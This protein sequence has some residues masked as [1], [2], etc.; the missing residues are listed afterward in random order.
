MASS[1]STISRS[2]APLLLV[3]LAACE[4][5]DGE[6]RK[7]DTEEQGAVRNVTLP[8][9]PP[10]L[11][12][13]TLSGSIPTFIPA[14]PDS[15]QQL[16][17]DS[18]PAAARP[19]FDSFSWQSFIALNWPAADGERGVPQAPGDSTVFL[20]A[21]NGTPVVWG[22]YKESYELY[23]Q[24]D[25]RPSPWASWDNPVDVCGGGK[26]GQKVFQRVSKGTSVLDQVDEAFSYPLV[27]QNLQYSRY[28]VRY[29]QAYYDTVRGPDSDPTRWMYL[30]KNLV[31]AMPFQMPATDSGGAV[32]ALMIKA[33]WRPMA[34]NDDRSRFYVID[35]QVLESD[36]SCSTVSMGLVGLHIAQKLSGFPQWI[37]STFEHVG[38]VPGPGSQPPYSYNNGLDTP[39]TQGGWANRPDTVGVVPDSLRARAQVVRLNPIPTTPQG[40]STR[41]VNAIYQ[42]Y[43][44]G[45]VWANYE[46][47]VTQ[48][49][50]NP[51]TFRYME[52]G[53]VYPK[54]SGTAFPVNG[55]VNT[56][57][58]TFFQSPSDAAGAGGNSCMSCHYRADYTDY[59][60][61][62]KRRAH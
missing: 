22:T 30:A 44:S 35:A 28:E 51:S 21:A 7:Q 23:E 34:P 54:G 9:L 16:P 56:T 31:K 50:A 25:D 43:L 41:D 6:R 17:P 37:W 18:I 36:G 4:G 55:A 8:P 59:S 12:Q 5:G 52:R 57:M 26:P 15:V 60:W 3:A 53:G 45:T 47:V 13:P 39:Q 58:E 2:C 19:W 14:I 11:P 61:V 33:A 1:R 48:W 49:P 62:L 46:L 24:G 27:D 38:N 32:G 40:A 10:G 20:Q 42:A 29:N